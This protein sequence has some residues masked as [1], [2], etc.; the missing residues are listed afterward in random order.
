MAIRDLIKDNLEKLQF[1]VDNKVL[2]GETTVLESKI[3]HVYLQIDNLC[4]KQRYQTNI[5]IYIY[6]IIKHTMIQGLYS[7]E[8]AEALNAV[9]RELEKYIQQL[10][11]QKEQVGVRYIPW[12][13]H[14]YNRC[15]MK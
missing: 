5:Y 13:I 8:R 10:A 11:I 4:K 15:I 12:F 3:N 2:G 7:E 1:V 14:I 6:S 9:G